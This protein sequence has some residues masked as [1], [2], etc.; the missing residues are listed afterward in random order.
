MIGRL[1]R[2]IVNLLIYGGTFI[3]LCAACITALTFELTG[4]VEENFRYILLVGAA[5]AALYCGHRVIGLH[6]TAFLNTSERFAIIRRYQFHIR[7]YAVLW[8][9]LALW[10][11]IPMASTTFML[12]LLPGGLVAFLYVLPVLPGG[13][14]L[15]DL[16]WGKILLIGWSW[17][18]LTAFIPLWLFAEAS[19]QMA[20]IHG[21]ERMMFIMLVAIPFE[22]RDLATDRS[23]GLITLPERM[24]KKRTSRMAVVLCTITIFLAFISSFHFFNPAYVIAISISG[25]LLLP[26]ILYSY[27]TTDDYYFAGVAD[28]MMII[29]LWIFTGA[30]YFV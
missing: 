24:G 29:A 26:L 3:G 11:F 17:A 30:N 1:V 10:L 28:G 2:D 16:G 7:V 8:G 4:S 21:L 22:I 5:T 27:N 25:V 12:W 23:A 13:R 15:R 6:K 18:W 19:I 9:L 20:V 14:R